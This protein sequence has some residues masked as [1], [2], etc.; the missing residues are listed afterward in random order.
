VRSLARCFL[1]F[2]VV[3]SSALP[4]SFRESFLFPSERASCFLLRQLPVSF[5]K[6]CF[7]F[8]FL[9]LRLLGSSEQYSLAVVFVV[10]SPL[11]TQ[12]TQKHQYHHKRQKLLS[13]CCRSSSKKNLKHRRLIWVD[14]RSL[15]DRNLYFFF[16]KAIGFDFVLHSRVHQ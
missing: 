1:S 9:S 6:S 7:L 12:K 11:K 15:H 10:L 13:L 2:V 3:T 4:V 14:A 16:L 5:R 8:P